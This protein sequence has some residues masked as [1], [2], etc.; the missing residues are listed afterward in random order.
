MAA[1]AAR[2]SHTHLRDYYEKLIKAGKKKMVAL[3]ALMHKIITIA[4]AKLKEM[5]KIQTT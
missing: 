4:N 5:E 2:N 1:M 3:V